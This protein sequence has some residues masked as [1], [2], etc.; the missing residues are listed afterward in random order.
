MVFL[1]DDKK[2]RQTGEY[3]WG[4]KRFAENSEKVVPIY[5]LL[6]LENLADEVF[7][8]GNAVLYHESFLDH[9]RL[10]AEA[11]DKRS[12]LEEFAIA[13]ENFQ[14][15]VFSGSK[16]SRKISGGNT[17][18]LP[19]SKLYQNLDVFIQ[20]HFEGEPDL[21]Y[22]LFGNNPSIE[23]ELT[24]E[25]NECI[26][27]IDKQEEQV[28]TD[29]RVFS[30]E[31]LFVQSYKN[32][33]Q[34]PILDAKL[35]KV[36]KIE[37]E[38][39]TS[40]IKS[41]LS[42]VK[43][44][45][46]FLPISIGET[47][48]DFNGLRLAT[49]IRC[50]PGLNQLSNIIIYSFVGLKA[51]VQ[52]EYFDILKTKNVSLVP[53]DKVAFAES[54]NQLLP[55][56][57]T[58]SE[59]PKEV[60]KLHLSPPKNYQDN[61]SVKNEWAIYQWA[62]ALNA[63]DDKEIQRIIGNV[64]HNIYFKYLK[65]T[66]LSNNWEI[67]SDQELE[68]KPRKDSKV[69]LID[70]ETNKGWHEIF[71]TLL[72]DRNRNR[73]DFH[74]LGDT[75]KGLNT[76][77]VVRQ[78]VDRILDENFDLVILDFRLQSDDFGINDPN[79]ITSIRILKEVKGKNPGVQVVVF[80]ATSKAWNLQAIQKAG[81]DGFV[82][83]DGSGNVTRSIKSLVSLVSDSLG[84]AKY[85][86]TVHSK[87]TKLKHLSKELQLSTNF[88]R[89]LAS[90]TDIVFQLI[91]KSFEE[92]KY[93]NYAYLQLFLIIEDFVKEASILASRSGELYVMYNG[94]D[95]KI[96]EVKRNLVRNCKMTFNKKERLYEKIESIYERQHV[97]TNFNVSALLI[98]RYG[99]NDSSEKNWPSIRDNRNEK[100][101]HPVKGNIP[102]KEFTDLIDFMIFLFDKRNAVGR[103]DSSLQDG[104][105]SLEKLFPGNK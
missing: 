36:I 57:L 78:S 88:E 77:E 51:L 95:H 41:R 105:K 90:N 20:K 15:A 73:I 85:L 47:L 97:D 3:W 70:D 38:D 68:V 1:I 6:Q 40:L 37:D 50:T 102:P 82:F 103:V 89:S 33:V 29:E 87:L 12:R 23:E 11:A 67:I 61:H 75:F 59:L 18:S 72:T 46:I 62:H 84:R 65:T 10:S 71:S 22:L 56:E 83:K 54:A 42:V 8:D 13:H 14:L 34:S 104:L 45:H 43:Y 9:T 16:N 60:L 69:L 44:D 35:E 66:S 93:R 31:I 86:K 53:Y 27:E 80:S 5:D 64:E 4:E 21:R 19:V 101:A 79:E 99:C 25:L 96:L 81:A 58:I 17:A 100:A 32:P 28:L 92:D 49:H 52:N 98:F 55:S 7:K 63:I 39:F 94:G 26:T 74:D 30:P 76:D 24:L 2:D 48:S 91:L